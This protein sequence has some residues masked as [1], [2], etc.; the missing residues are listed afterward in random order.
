MA[1]KPQTRAKKS[2]TKKAPKDVKATRK[3]KKATPPTPKKIEVLKECPDGG[4]SGSKHPAVVEWNRKNKTK[5]EFN[6]MYHR[7]ILKGVIDPA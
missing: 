7:A 3:T 5:K 1:P 2:T 4:I 6:A